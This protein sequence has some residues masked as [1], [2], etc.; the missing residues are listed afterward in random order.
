MNFFKHKNTPLNN[1]KYKNKS[2]KYFSFFIIF[3][4]VILGAVAIT[5]VFSSKKNNSTKHNT[6]IRNPLISNTYSRNGKTSSSLQYSKYSNH[7][8]NDTNYNLNADDHEKLFSLMDKVFIQYTVKSEFYW[9]TMKL[10]YVCTAEN[11]LYYTD[12]TFKKISVAEEKVPSSAQKIDLNTIGVTTHTSI[13]KTLWIGTDNGGLFTTTDGINFTPF[14]SITTNKFLGSILSMVYWAQYSMLMVINYDGNKDDKYLTC[15]NVK[16]KTTQTF[17]KDIQI[18]SIIYYE[19]KVIAK[20]FE[21][22]YYYIEY[23]GVLHNQVQFKVEKKFSLYPTNSGFQNYGDVLNKQFFAINN[24]LYSIGPYLI[25]YNGDSFSALNYFDNNQINTLAYVNSILWVGTSNGL[26]YRKNSDPANQFTY[27]K[28]TKNIVIKTIAKD[29]S[30]FLYIGTANSGVYIHDLSKSNDSYY[31]RINSM[32]DVDCVSISTFTDGDDNFLFLNTVSG[33]Y[34]ENKGIYFDPISNS[35]INKTV[36][37]WYYLTSDFILIANSTDDSNIK[38]ND[39][40]MPNNKI[41]SFSDISS[42]HPDFDASKPVVIQYN[43][44]SNQVEGT[45]YFTAIILRKINFNA[46]STTSSNNTNISGFSDKT[47]FKCVLQNRTKTKLDFRYFLSRDKTP[48]IN[49]DMTKSINNE[50]IDYSKSVYFKIKKDGKNDQ[51]YTTNKIG[52]KSFKIDGTSDGTLYEFQIYDNS[53]NLSTFIIQIG[54][55]NIMLKTIP[56]N[57]HYLSVKRRK[58]AIK[59]TCSVIGAIILIIIIMFVIRYFL[60]KR[61]ENVKNDPNKYASNKSIVLKSKK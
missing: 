3:L 33:F 11:G 2:I 52:N 56:N 6:T 38:I 45:N 23:N 29:S 53:G 18:I 57:H 46:A 44:S 15:V 31:F 60:I 32:Q 21:S 50:Y 22:N 35:D 19:S 16:D 58:E 48:Y 41:Y 24:T 51:G 14:Q 36:N 20:D 39:K 9:S 42:E 1:H 8:F 40:S 27:I 59:I 47:S 34:K 10:Y 4:L 37:N 7:N 28:S 26:Y 25:S 54:G 17:F 43:S 12:K 55:K 61:S 30:N 13:D 49:F 5:G